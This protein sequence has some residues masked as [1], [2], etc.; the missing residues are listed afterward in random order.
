MQIIYT[1]TDWLWANVIGYTLLGV[2]LYFTIKLGFPQ[3]KHFIRAFSTMKKSLKGDEGGLSGFG[4]L[5]AALGGQLGTGS[6]VGV[7]SA[8]F[9]G[10]P[11]AIFWM[12]MTALFGMIVSFSETVL[13][14]AFRI[15]DKDGNYEGGP[16]YYIEK[17]LRNK[18]LAIL[19]SLLYVFGI[20][21][22]IASIQ[23]NSIAN[24]FTG[25]VNINPIIPGIIVV[26]LAFL[27]TIGGMKRLV[28][29]STFIVPFMVF[30]YFSVVLYIVIINITYIP[31]IF[32][33]IFESAFTGKSAVGGVV[34]WTVAEAFRSGVAR[35]MF[36]NDA[37]NGSAAMM[38]ASADVKH[39]VDQGFLAMIGTFITTIIICTAT[40]LAILMTG[41]LESGQDG[42]L[43]LQT[44][45]GSVLGNLGSWI[46]FL[47]MFLF[48]FTTLLADMR[49]GESNLTYIFKDKKKYPILSY[50]VV[51][52]VILVMASVV[53]LNVIW[54][55]VD[56]ILGMIV[57]I[58]VISLLL[59]FKYVRYIYQHYF[60][61]VEKGNDNPRWNY[62]LDITKIDLSYV[63]EPHYKES[64][65]V[66][67][68]NK[69]VV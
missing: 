4:T 29:V 17:G 14:Q 24:A 49:Y 62:D 50:R 42:I 40:A 7:S 55:A 51:L 19:I 64:T 1:I 36:S 3:I 66:E 2:G 48:G 59:L 56:L 22:A 8:L 13:G 39:P 53:E 43:L 32:D 28:N 61:E 54:A 35:G 57:F 47:A 16:A 31:T 26:I 5:M 18:P 20:G 69:K 21:I 44:A 34:G 52:A 11:G 27:V 45:F 9:I 15:K 60:R 37:G 30:V 33:A 23:T 63:D 6:L 68:K 46:V 65:D 38:H 67:T 10:G 41:S 25:V 12:W 58:N